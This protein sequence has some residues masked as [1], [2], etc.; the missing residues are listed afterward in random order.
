[1]H[2]RSCNFGFGERSKLG[3]SVKAVAPSPNK[4]NLRKFPHAGSVAHRMGLSRDQATFGSIKV[5]IKTKASNPAPCSYK[6]KGTLRNT[7]FTIKERFRT[8]ESY[9][10]SP[11]P[12]EYDLVCLNEKGAYP[13]SQYKNTRTIIMDA[14]KN[15]PEKMKEGPGPAACTSIS[16]QTTK[17]RPPPASA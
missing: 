13:V 1:M 14:C 10:R 6:I 8:E 3:A 5:E 16:T 15:I 9:R 4:Y 2:S 7:K 11:G 12:G 17:P